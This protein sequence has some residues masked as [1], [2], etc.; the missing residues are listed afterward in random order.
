MLIP[1]RDKSLSSG[2]KYTGDMFHLKARI[3][4][5]RG[6]GADMR[7][8]SVTFLGSRWFFEETLYQKR[9]VW[10]MYKCSFVLTHT[11]LA[12]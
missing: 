7:S 3:V 4:I 5:D 2:K 9:H 10:V 11:S 6:F 12:R 8:H 1:E